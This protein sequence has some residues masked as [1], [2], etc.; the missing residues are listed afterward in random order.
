MNMQVIIKYEI[1]SNQNG[2]CEMRGSYSE[3]DAAI[4]GLSSIK[5]LLNDGGADEYEFEIRCVEYDYVQTKDSYPKTIEIIN[6]L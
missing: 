1:W 4:E 5:K 3:K 6:K 2:L